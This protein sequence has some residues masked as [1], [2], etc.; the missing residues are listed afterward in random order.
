MKSWISGRCSRIRS[1]FTWM[2]GIFGDARKIYYGYVDPKT[3]KSYMFQ[4][5]DVM[6]FKTWYSLDGVTRNRC[7]R[8]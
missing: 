1:A 3:G 6:H 2:T 8:S 7:A 4:S 5:D